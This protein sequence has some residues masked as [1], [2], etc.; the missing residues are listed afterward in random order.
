MKYRRH[1]KPFTGRL[2]AAPWASLFFLLLTLLLF[3]TYLVPPPGVR[4]ELP[5]VDT[6][7]LPAATHP[8]LAV[9]IDRVGR[10]Y[11]ESQVVTEEELG[12][13]LAEKVRASEA[14][15]TLLLQADRHVAQ[16]VI[17]RLHELA[18]RAGVREV[19]LAT[20]PELFP[21]GAGGPDEA[22]P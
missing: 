6:P 21:A 4:I 22:R 1:L 7:A 11:F 20:R 10:V 16:E 15:V 17:L 12:R 9:A 8:W 18:R 13:R 3:H 14:P 2:D 19:I 5:V